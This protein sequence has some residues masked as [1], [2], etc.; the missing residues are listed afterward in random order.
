M[1]VYQ[2]AEAFRL[3]TGSSPNVARMLRYFDAMN[4]NVRS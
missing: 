2:A 4:H 3:F 1:A